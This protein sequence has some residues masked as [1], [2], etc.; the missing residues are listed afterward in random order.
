MCNVYPRPGYLAKS[1]EVA[2]KNILGG[3]SN[4]GVIAHAPMTPHVGNRFL[5]WT[6]SAGN[7]LE[8]N[9]FLQAQPMGPG[10]AVTRL[11]DKF[12]N[13]WKH[14]LEK[15]NIYILQRTCNP[16]KI[17]FKFLIHFKTNMA[18]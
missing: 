16:V 11:S 8:S 15:K 9:Q 6:K 17:V 7:C 12:N 18:Q 10:Q 4:W 14:I 3:H 1:R 2:G 13:N 5:I